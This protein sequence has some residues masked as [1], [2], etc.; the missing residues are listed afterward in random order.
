MTA[1]GLLLACWPATLEPGCGEVCLV[2][3]SGLPGGSVMP[4]SEFSGGLW[5]PG[6]SYHA[7]SGVFWPALGSMVGSE[8]SL[9]V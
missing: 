2:V 7:P 1:L 6:P 4:F 8:G 3:L 5:P 9:P